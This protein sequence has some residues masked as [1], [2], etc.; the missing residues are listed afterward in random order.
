M[1]YY[2]K[3]KLLAKVCIIWY[4][5]FQYNYSLLLVE[6]YPDPDLRLSYSI[7]RTKFSWVCMHVDGF[8]S[9]SE[10][11]WTPKTVIWDYDLSEIMYSFAICATNLHGTVSY[12]IYHIACCVY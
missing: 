12:G 9:D 5:K 7:A 6:S 4:E 10:D 3:K 8:S 2:Y 1:R 11:D